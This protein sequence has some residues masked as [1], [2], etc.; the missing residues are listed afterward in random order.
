MGWGLGPAG[1]SFVGAGAVIAIIWLVSH[2]FDVR[3]W[4]ELAVFYAVFTAGFSLI[5]RQRAMRDQARTDHQY[6]GNSLNR[7]DEFRGPARS[8]RCST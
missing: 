4:T 1:P 2:H 8:A 3:L 7:S 5:R 6:R